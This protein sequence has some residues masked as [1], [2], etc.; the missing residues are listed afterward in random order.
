LAKDLLT[1]K[2]EKSGIKQTNKKWDREWEQGETT[3]KQ[4]EKSGKK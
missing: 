4:S 1:T 2:R 3:E